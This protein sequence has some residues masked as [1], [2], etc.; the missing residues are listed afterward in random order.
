MGAVQKLN[1][2]VHAGLLTTT[3]NAE[4]V[5]KIA[6]REDVVNRGKHIRR[7]LLQE[8]SRTRCAPAVDSVLKRGID[9]D[10]EQHIG[11]IEGPTNGVNQH[12]VVGNISLR[13][14]TVLHKPQQRSQVNG[15]AAGREEKSSNNTLDNDGPH[16]VPAVDA[17]EFE[18]LGHLCTQN[19]LKTATEHTNEELV[20]LLLVEGCRT[21][22]HVDELAGSHDGLQQSE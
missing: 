2:L 18:L 19:D 21:C 15:R 6:P 12:T 11:A 17:T 1:E 10:A 4:R 14:K 22:I 3:H 20:E 13:Q 16:A 5:I 8:Y 7:N 9:R